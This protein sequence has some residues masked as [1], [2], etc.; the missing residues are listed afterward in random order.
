MLV[1]AKAPVAGLVKTRL[2]AGIGSDAAAEV[3]AASLLDTLSACSEAVGPGRCH[4]AVA[5][6]LAAAVRGDEL[7]RAARGWTV[8]PQRGDGFTARLVNAH[9]DLVD[10]ASPVVQIGMDTPQVTPDLLLEAAAGTREHEAV[11]GPAEDGGW[12]V[13]ALDDP[14]HAA[15]LADVVMSTPT[16]HDETRRALRRHGLRVGATATLRDVD[17]VEDADAVSAYQPAGHFT[18]AWAGVR[19][20]LA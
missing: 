19:E 9:L 12:W 6:D 4:L 17:T 7:V 8:R 3:A 18:R 10:G 20:V 11:L 1:L 14:Q 5:G 13:L 2:G 15:A 16:T